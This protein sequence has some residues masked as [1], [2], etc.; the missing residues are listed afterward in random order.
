VSIPARRWGTLVALLALI[1]LVGQAC[2]IGP[3]RAGDPRTL[4]VA[5]EP[6]ELTKRLPVRLVDHTGLVTSMVVAGPALDQVELLA[7]WNPPGRPD[8]L[9]VQWLGGACDSSVALEFDRTEAGFG[10][11]I[12]TEQQLVLGCV[13]AGISRTVRLDFS[14]DVDAGTVAFGGG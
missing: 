12:H 14:A 13:A 5:F 8:A 2:T 1:V 9:L 11:T 4:E 7:V 3:S 6:G 10:L